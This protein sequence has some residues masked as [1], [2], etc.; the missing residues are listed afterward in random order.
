MNPYLSV[1]Q[2]VRPAILAYRLLALE[3]ERASL[4]ASECEELLALTRELLTAAGQEEVLA[5]TA[6]LEPGGE[7]L[8]DAYAD[9]A[10]GWAKVTGSLLALGG[11]LVGR[12]DW[13]GARRVAAALAAAGERDAAIDLLAQLGKAMW[14]GYHERLRQ[15]RSQMPP[16]EIAACLALLRAALRDVP[17]EFAGR[18]RDISRVL[19]PLACAI[20]AFMADRGIEPSLDSRVSHIADGGVAAYPEIVDMSVAELC[21][22]FDGAC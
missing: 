8:A 6:S 14:G 9:A 5:T 3:Q 13:D 15:V 2:A 10:L 22:E 11:E 18:D 19:V 16:A 7:G 4:L 17:A 20:R 21:A 12:G 1:R